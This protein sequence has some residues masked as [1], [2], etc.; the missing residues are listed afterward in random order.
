[1]PKVSE[2]QE[3]GHSCPR[4]LSTVIGPET[5]D[6]TGAWEVFLGKEDDAATVDDV[7]TKRGFD[8]SHRV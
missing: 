3:R 1:M 7:Q 2:R 6:S 5:W 8:R 4:I